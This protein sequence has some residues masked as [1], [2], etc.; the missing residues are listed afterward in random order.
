MKRILTTSLIPII[1]SA[2]LF[3]ILESGDYYTVEFYSGDAVRGFWSA[4]LIEMFLV[5][6]S[7]VYFTGRPVL[8][9]VVKFIMICLFF[10]MIGGASLKIVGPM[11]DE[12]STANNS[13]R[14]IEFLISQNDQSK[15]NLNLLSGQRT[16]TALQTKFHRELVSDTVTELKK[17]GK[18]SSALWVSILFTTFLRVSVQTA[19][20]IMAYILGILWREN[21]KPRLGV[22]DR[23]EKTGR[24]IKK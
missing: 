18:D 9:W 11:L 2:S 17:D 24:F 6:F 7:V 5:V 16:N 14:L 20:L 15:T 19:N 12:L 4:A 21:F 22:V 8:N 13:D 3:M 23:D 10:V 1:I